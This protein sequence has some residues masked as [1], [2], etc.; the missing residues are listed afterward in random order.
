MDVRSKAIFNSNKLKLGWFCPNTISGMTK[1]HEMRWLRWSEVV[2]AATIADTAGIEALTPIARWKGYVD[3]DPDHIS[4]Q[5]IDAFSCAAGLAQATRYSTIFATSHAPT[6]HPVA[7]A[8]QAASI[9]EISNGRF[10]L[11]IVGG[12]NRREFEMFGIELLEHAERY[13][14]LADWL[15]VLRKLWTGEEFDYQSKYFSMKGAVCQPRLRSGHIPIMNA[16]TS[17]VGMRF[18]AKNSDLGFCTP[19]GDDPLAWTDEIANYKALARDEF[20]RDI[21]IWTNASVVQRQTDAEAQDFYEYYTEDMVD[22]VAIDSMI[23]TMVRENGWAGDDKRIGFM[24][25]RMIGGSG[26]PLIGS[27]ET[28]ANKLELMTKAGIDGVLMSWIDPI[29]GLT[30]FTR[31]VLPILEEKGLR[32]PFPQV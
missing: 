25:K 30:R 23:D 2:A 20:D 19:R 17:T 10:A 22:E 28:I 31:D 7:I 8:K 16:A 32:V 1:A 3:G 14:Y 5:I 15:G 4:N 6:I 29:D 18:A 27:A 12:W 26:F 13:E 9:D 21:K 24:R 11:N